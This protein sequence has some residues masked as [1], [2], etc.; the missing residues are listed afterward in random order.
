MGRRC[1]RHLRVAKNLPHN[2]PTAQHT[3]SGDNGVEPALGGNMHDGLG[4]LDVERNPP[5]SMQRKDVGGGSV[6]HLEPG[7]ELARRDVLVAVD[8]HLGAA[9][10]IV[11][12][13]NDFQT[14]D[15][16]VLGQFRGLVSVLRRAVQDGDGLATRHLRE[17]L[18]EPVQPSVPALG[19]SIRVRTSTLVPAKTGLPPRICGLRS[20]APSVAVFRPGRRGICG[21]V[22]CGN[23]VLAIHARSPR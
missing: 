23:C 17:F 3:R 2:V 15:A 6:D 9:R 20:I 14:G 1:G 11:D 19:C 8:P 12:H 13:A 21:I 18:E 16:V 7:E 22:Y 10:A 4:G 5:L